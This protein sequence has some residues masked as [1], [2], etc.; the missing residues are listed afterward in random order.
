[1]EEHTFEIIIIGDTGVGKSCLLLRFS[2]DK[3]K[4]NHEVTIGVEY[5]T[6]TLQIEN[7][8]LGLRIWDT[9][10]QEA[11]RSIARSFY[12][13]ANGVLLTYDVT[14]RHTFDNLPYWLEEISKNCN[15][16]VIVFLIGNQADL[17]D[18]NQNPEVSKAEVE[19]FVSS[20]NLSGFAETS[21]K[22]G[23][24]VDYVFE[25][26]S[27]VFIK[28]WAE[29][30]ESQLIPHSDSMTVSKILKPQKKVKKKCC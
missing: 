25:E 13:R 9:A 20:N 29:M 15:N 30:R 2:E 4:E 18:S 7:I 11:Y 5:G 22:T 28:R 24:N 19:K 21:A 10:G 3:F 12:R 17:L 8:S 16:D 26:F 6:R 1:M 23:Y 14:A 27:A